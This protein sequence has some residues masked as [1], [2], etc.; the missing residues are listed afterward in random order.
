VAANLGIT[1]VPGLAA[2]GLRPD[3]ALVRIRSE[4]P[5]SRTVLVATRR[6]PSPHPPAVALVERLHEAAA[7]LAA[8]LRSRLS[9]R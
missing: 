2:A 3:V 8:E 4:R 7:E 9:R 1:L 6:G 5:A